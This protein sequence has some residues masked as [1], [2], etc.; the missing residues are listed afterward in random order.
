MKT[1]ARDFKVFCQECLRL[2]K[3]W[4]LEMWD[5]KFAHTELDYGVYANCHRDAVGCW[6]ELSL[7]KNW[8]SCKAEPKT[9]AA[10]RDAARHEM[11]HVAI[12]LVGNLANER[13]VTR[14]QLDSAEHLTVQ[15]LMKALIG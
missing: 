2:Q 13:Y 5:L 14:E 9:D 7:A 11:C 4:G 10:I 8:P 3:L 1:T 12:G 15:I 6:A